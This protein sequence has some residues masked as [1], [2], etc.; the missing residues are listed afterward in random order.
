MV[1]AHG[2]ALVFLLS[3]VNIVTA[4]NQLC[5][6]GQSAPYCICGAERQAN[7]MSLDLTINTNPPDDN[8]D[9]VLGM[10]FDRPY[11]QG[12]QTSIILVP[13]FNGVAQPVISL[14]KY[15]SIPPPWPAGFTSRSINIGCRPLFRCTSGGEFFWQITWVDQVGNELLCVRTQVWNQGIQANSTNTG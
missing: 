11:V 8:I 14:L 13:Y 9:I 7:D 15:I 4:Q 3:L 5:V 6:N 2:T 12:T 1:L 10:T